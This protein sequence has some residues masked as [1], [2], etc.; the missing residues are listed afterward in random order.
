M[1]HII[2]GKPRKAPHIK[3]GCGKDGNSTLYAIELSEQLTDRQSGEKTYTN[4]KAMLFASSQA[5]KSYYDR[6][7]A[8]GSFVVVSCE[9]LKVESRD[10]NGKTYITLNMENARLENAMFAEG[11]NQQQQPQGH[12]RS[13]QQQTQGGSGNQK[14]PQGNVPPMDFDSE[15]P[16]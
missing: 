6:A 10:Y 7:F 8:E 11:G 2:S 14:Q 5:H 9:K 15:I 16:F 3:D 13:P 1:S 4:Y 12:Q